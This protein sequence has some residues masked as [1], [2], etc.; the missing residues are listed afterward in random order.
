MF[1]F[2]STWVLARTRA[3]AGWARRGGLS[4]RPTRESGHFGPRVAV[5]DDADE[6]TRLIAFVGWQ[7]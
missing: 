6:Q 1:L 2:V 4:R 5:P 3:E 7:P